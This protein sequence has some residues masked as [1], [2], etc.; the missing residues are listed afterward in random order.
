MNLPMSL[1]SWMRCKNTNSWMN[2]PFSCVCHR[3]L[4]PLKCYGQDVFIMVLYVDHPGFSGFHFF[5]SFLNKTVLLPIP[6]WRLGTSFLTF[7]SIF[8][9][10]SLR[11]V[12]KM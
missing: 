5:L 12:I 7:I 4:G 10:F 8:V 6:K 9:C 1:C 11:F 2:C 3:T